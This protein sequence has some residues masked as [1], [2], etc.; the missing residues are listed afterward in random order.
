MS[1]SLHNAVKGAT[2]KMRHATGKLF[3]RITATKENEALTQAPSLPTTQVNN[4]SGGESDAIL[5]PISALSFGS[6]AER[7]ESQGKPPVKEFLAA[8][9][10]ATK[11]TAVN[12]KKYYGAEGKE[13]FSEAE[14][15]NDVNYFS[16][17]GFSL[18]YFHELV[19]QW[20][21]REAL[22]GMTT[23]DICNDKIKPATASSGLSLSAQL[24]F[25]QPALVKD[26]Q[27]FVSHAWSYL[28][29]DVLEA[30]DL[31]C[32]S[33]ELDPAT[34][35]FWFDCMTVSQHQSGMATRNFNWW[36]TVFKNAVET[37]GNVV[38][39]MQPWD[40]PKPLKRSWCLFEIFTA[41]VT[42]STFKIS[43]PAAQRSVFLQTLVE[44]GAVKYYDVLLNI[45]VEQSD[46]TVKADR[47]QILKLAI[48]FGL[49]NLHQSVFVSIS[50][51]IVNAM[52]EQLLQQQD[53]LGK[54][55]WTNALADFQRQLGNYDKAEPLYKACLE[56]TRETVGREHPAT[57]ACINNIAGLY[58]S[59]GK[60]QKA[61]PLYLEC[62]DASIKIL[63]KEHPDT[64]ISINNLAALYK[65]QGKYDQAGPLLV[66]VLEV[67]ET[68]L[69]QEHPDTL[70]SI[71]NL[72]TLYESLG[73][74]EK[75]EALYVECLHGRQKIFGAEH[76]ETLTSLNN[77]AG[78]YESQGMDGKAEPLHVACL[79]A[80][81][82]LLGKE[83]PDTLASMNN[84]AILYKHQGKYDKAEL[85]YGEC[86]DT[87]IKTLGNVHPGTLVSVNNLAGLYIA[88]GK[89]DDAELLF[90]NALDAC[91]TAF[92]NEHPDT[93]LCMENLAALY[94]LQG[95][96]NKAEPLLVQSVALKEKILGQWHP[97]TMASIS[98]LGAF[99]T[100]Q[101]KYDKAEPWFVKAVD[102][103][104]KVYGKE[105][106][107]TLICMNNL[108]FIYESEKKYH[109]AEQLHLAALE[110]RIKMHGKGHPDTQASKQKLAVLYLAQG[111]YAKAASLS[112]V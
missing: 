41:N 108:A 60:F 36:T 21:G 42:N 44:G 61:E 92:G 23:S 73:N 54:T 88:Q 25:E 27:W 33:S 97:D 22:A 109:Q 2:T 77:L 35:H 58:E 48:D 83:H 57:L 15:M 71:N 96:V 30:L 12:A 55:K 17:K 20:G 1:Q 93:V 52:E 8:D 86:L 11:A 32:E 94:K 43:M 28:F 13:Y 101:G 84:L 50:D 98:N 31:F 51:W 87:C 111:K 62:L 3:A 95:M 47:D 75:A 56:Y 18:S 70:T 67:R 99:F 81:M 4:E 74:F 91:K 104:I 26:A 49:T 66:Q 34:T 102:A 80:R 24:Y 7:T 85:L 64:L 82:K 6:P 112:K 10:I 38:L 14:A 103:H 79:E 5:D 72:A 107:D 45:N 53:E 19:E 76:P 78:L 90:K 100:S 89:H 59:Q 68:T 69:G 46:A 16:I 105:Y 40:D 65:S 106:S 29:L 37:I 110:V 39:V 63:G 9:T